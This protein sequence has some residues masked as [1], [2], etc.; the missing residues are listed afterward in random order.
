MI[1]SEEWSEGTISVN[2]QRTRNEASGPEF[3]GLGKAFALFKQVFPDYDKTWR[4]DELRS[5][6]FARL[7]AGGHVYLDYTGGSL[8]SDKQ[9]I[10]HVDLLRHGVYGNPHSNSP[11]SVASTQMADRA[12]RYVLEYFDASPDEY[13][14]IFTHNAS[15]ALKIIGESYP[16]GPTSRYL[17]T[18]DNHN[19]VNGI[20]EFARAKGADVTYVRNVAPELRIDGDHLRRELAKPN[21]NGRNLFA[22]PAQSN[23]SGVQHS[24]DW[25]ARAQ[26]QGWDVVLDAAAFVPTNRLDLSKYHPDFVPLSFYKMIGYPT[27]VGCLIAKRSA[28]KHL[29]PPWFAGGTIEMASVQGD[30]YYLS[31]GES[32]FEEG[33]INYLNLPAIEIG[34]RNLRSLGIQMIHERVS[35][36]TSWLLEQLNKLH[37]SNGAPVVEIYGPRN[38]IERGATIA[39]N[40]RDPAGTVFNFHDVEERASRRNISLRTGCFCNPGAGELAF[41]L[42]RADIVDC[43]E[44]DKRASFERCIISVKGKTAGAVRVSLGLVSNFGDAFH[45][46]EF[47]RSF[48]KT[49]ADSKTGDTLKD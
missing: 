30:R 29:R 16:F 23:F 31:D 18:F 26:S 11:S 3:R 4:V 33:T 35:Y 41:G 12:R 13:A 49:A 9:L 42:T 15:G 39:L 27:G 19:A 2:A 44:N 14:V 6:D 20:R 38:A 40:F 24:L 10:E 46:V 17:L 45:F 34:L 43:F 25:I 28:L 48:V 32:A 47:A 5:R 1:T 7:D 36:L 37:H 21:P 8:Y 22:L